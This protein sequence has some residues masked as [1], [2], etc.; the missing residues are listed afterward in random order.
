MVEY[1]QNAAGDCSPAG[2]I[3]V[4]R[5]KKV[6]LVPDSFKGTLSSVRICELCERK[7]HEHFPACEVVS[8]PVAD[9]GEGSVDCFL[10]ALGG[11]RILVPSKNPFLEDMTGFYGILSGGGEKTAVIE[12]AA[13]AGLPLV[14]GR[15]DAMRATTYGVGLLLRDCL[16]RSCKKIILGLGGSATTDMGLGAVC[17]LGGRFLD[18]DGNAFL[19]VGGRLS[20]IRH[21]DLSEMVPIPPD[22]SV[23]GMCD[24]DNVLYGR[25]GAAYVFAPQKGASQEQ[26]KLLDDGLR[27][28]AEVVKRELGIDVTD[29]P[30]GGAA[31]GMGAGIHAFLRA[32]LRSGIETVLE[33]VQF[34][35]LLAGADLCISG[36]GRL[37]R[38]SLMGKVIGGVARHTKRQ[39]V[40]L[41]A[42]VGGVSYDVGNVYD[43]GV[44]AVFTINRLPESLSESGGRSEENLLFAL[45]NILRLAEVV[46]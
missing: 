40:P 32:E 8:V 6:V 44:Q 17:A 2:K 10:H 21:I 20:E 39:Q 11:E 25:N 27:S 42:L 28:A 15:K 43:C 29:I 1:R 9:G 46:K 3:G 38:Q 31:G 23:I 5:M 12:M 16:R 26:V 35:T 24:I 34:D 33:T 45:E 37:D 36:E 41:V 22:V 7:I 13:C 18:A 30:G 19:P 4:C 14:E